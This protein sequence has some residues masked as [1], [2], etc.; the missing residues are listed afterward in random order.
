[1]EPG[2]SLPHSQGPATCPYPEPA[3]SIRVAYTERK[4]AYK[5]HFKE[6]NR[7]KDDDSGLLRYEAGL[8][9]SGSTRFERT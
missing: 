9:V 6:E 2:G 8:C 5:I 4:Y 1:M 3:Q 7:I